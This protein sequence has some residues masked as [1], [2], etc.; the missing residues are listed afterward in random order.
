MFIHLPTLPHF[1]LNDQIRD[2]IIPGEKW[3]P[4][5]LGFPR[6]R[7][8]IAKE[9]VEGTKWRSEERER[10]VGLFI[11]QG[12]SEHPRGVFSSWVKSGRDFL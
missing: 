10:K 1:S 12:G 2:S 7:D 3:I 5:L 4:L 9:L 11:R 6:R 8:G